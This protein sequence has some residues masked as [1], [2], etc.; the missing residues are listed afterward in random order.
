[1][2]NPAEHKYPNVKGPPNYWVSPE[3]GF[4]TLYPKRIKK[5]AQNV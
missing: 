1:M 2:Q 4:W 3:A 5:N